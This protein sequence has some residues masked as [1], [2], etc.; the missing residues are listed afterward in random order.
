MAPKQK[1]SMSWSEFCVRG[2]VLAE[3]H[4]MCIFVFINF[5]FTT[6]NDEE[7]H[8]REKLFLKSNCVIPLLT[9][10]IAIIPT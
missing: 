3:D 4:L 6:S 10:S 5:V 1:P 7:Q 8:K 2:T 9:F